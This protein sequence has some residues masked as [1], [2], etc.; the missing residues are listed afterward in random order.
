MGIS[1]RRSRSGGSVQA[2][3]AEAVEEVLAEAP[4][5]DQR[6]EVGVGGDDQADVDAARLRIA[7]RVNLVRFQEAQQLGLD[8][9]AGIADLVEEQRA[10][11]GRAYDAREVVDGA[12]ERAAPVA[13]QLRIE[14]V[15]RASRCS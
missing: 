12:G 13:E 14:H 8:V 3:D 1:T 6:V 11:G 10:A 15:L 5:A 7:N 4:L 2:D 9:E